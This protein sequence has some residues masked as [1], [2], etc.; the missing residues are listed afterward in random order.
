MKDRVTIDAVAYRVVGHRNALD[1]RQCIH[2][3]DGD[4]RSVDQVQLEVALARQTRQEGELSLLGSELSQEL[5]NCRS[6]LEDPLLGLEQ[7]AFNA[8]VL[9]LPGNCSQTPAWGGFSLWVFE[10]IGDLE[11]ESIG[12]L[13]EAIDLRIRVLPPLSIHD[14]RSQLFMVK[15]NVSGCLFGFPLKKHSHCS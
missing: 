7:A 6:G 3:D 10:E 9:T 14:A 13:V 4:G 12:G 1:A 8:P 11:G 2:P 5:L 15:S